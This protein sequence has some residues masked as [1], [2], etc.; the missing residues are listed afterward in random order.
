MSALKSQ[1]LS[2]A[3][4]VKSMPVIS[5]LN[6]HSISPNDIILCLRNLQAAPFSTEPNSES[7]LSLD[8]IDRAV[9]QPSAPADT[10]AE[11]IFLLFWTPDLLHRCESSECAA[12]P[13]TKWTVS[14]ECD[15]ISPQYL[16]YL[17]LHR[18]H[19]FVMESIGSSKLEM[20][21]SSQATSLSKCTVLKELVGCFGNSPQDSDSAAFICTVASNALCGVSVVLSCV[22]LNGS[23]DLYHDAIAVC[24]ALHSGAYARLYSHPALEMSCAEYITLVFSLV[25][26]ISAGIVGAVQLPDVSAR[27]TCI[28]E[29][30]RACVCLAAQ[31]HIGKC[32]VGYIATAIVHGCL[33]LVANIGGAAKAPFD[34]CCVTL[35]LLSVSLSIIDDIVAD[36]PIVQTGPYAE[37]AV[38]FI[39]GSYLSTDAILKLIAS[40]SEYMQIHCISEIVNSLKMKLKEAA[41]LAVRMEMHAET[42]AQKEL[43]VPEVPPAAL[44][45]AQP[46]SRKKDDIR[47]AINTAARLKKLEEEKLAAEEAIRLEEQRL[48][49]VKAHEEALIQEALRKET[50]EQA[51]RDQ[52]LKEMQAQE[53]KKEVER[54][55]VSIISDILMP[56]DIICYQNNV[57]KHAQQMAAVIPDITAEDDVMMLNVAPNRV[58]NSHPIMNSK[59][60]ILTEPQP[61]AEAQSLEANT[62]EL[63]TATPSLVHSPPPVSD[64]IA[65]AVEASTGASDD[66]PDVV[67][68]VTTPSQLTLEKLANEMKTIPFIPSLKRP[69]DITTVSPQK[70]KEMK[71]KEMKEKRQNDLK[72]RLAEEKLK[73]EQKVAEKLKKQR[74]LAAKA[75]KEEIKRRKDME[76]EREA[77]EQL[78]LAEERVAAAREERRLKRIAEH[79]E[80]IRLERE[81]FLKKAQSNYIR[82]NDIDK[83]DVIADE[84]DRKIDAEDPISNYCAEDFINMIPPVQPNVPEENEEPKIE[85]T[86]EEKESKS[87]KNG[88]SKDK[89]IGEK[90]LTKEK[91]KGEKDGCV[92]S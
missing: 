92:I 66:V 33:K 61:K 81:E 9:C 71:E 60:V 53:Q 51:H 49:A 90:H 38:T 43:D 64:L 72:K 76:A 42:S 16:Y 86:Q 63:P 57:T 30:K 15:R 22:L 67:P 4:L 32:L 36:T 59:A 18:F 44:S 31:E 52:I 85:G 5:L 17:Q 65:A 45:T 23:P 10:L 74:E 50:E 20:L 7:L 79:Q 73:N 14:P 47:D 77:E 6:H 70:I 68:S 78:K 1:A 11:H 75:V 28:N 39:E 56:I 62:I 54:M 37:V 21:L 29:L 41:E 24:C 87:E 80:R 69:T 91:K 26:V 58:R 13:L 40:C 2:G 3:G 12:L 83:E 8:S 88:K 25:L 82:L 19:H 27:D 89:R 46:N 84:V 55:I 34:G 48:A 35:S